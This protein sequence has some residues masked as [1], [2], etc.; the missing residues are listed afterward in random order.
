VETIQTVTKDLFAIDGV[1]GI[2]ISSSDGKIIF[3]DLTR[4]GDE[5]FSADGLEILLSL[6]HDIQEADLLFGAYRVNVRSYSAGLF[7]V[8]MRPDT[9]AAMVRLQC[10]VLAPRLE[11]KTKKKGIGRFFR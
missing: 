5:E 6:F 8:I 3:K 11:A 9:S 2:L 10:D 4:I 1:M 7:W